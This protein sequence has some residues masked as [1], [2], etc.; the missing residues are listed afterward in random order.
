MGKAEV[1]LD[2]QYGPEVT[3]PGQ[4]EVAHGEEVVVNCQVSANPSD[5]VIMWTKE[6]VPGC[7]I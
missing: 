2:V 3:V 4:R 7:R 5:V 6:G 1:E